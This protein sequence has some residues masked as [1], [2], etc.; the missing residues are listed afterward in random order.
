MNP[1]LP[2]PDPR[3]NPSTQPPNYYGQQYPPY[4]QPAP[5]PVYVQAP[6]TS[7][8]ATASLVLG[9]IGILGGWCV[10]GIPCLMAI[11]LGHLG[12]NDTKDGRRAGRGSA[13][14]GLVLGY[15]FIVP[16]V[17]IT[18]WAVLGNLLPD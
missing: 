18:F 4:G 15:L 13:V 10:F 5:Q 11:I 12:L 1:Y 9:I 16:A 7:G 6:Q 8:L 14:A 3:W 2:E 17:L